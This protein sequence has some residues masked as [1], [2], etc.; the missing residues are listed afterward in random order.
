L[1]RCQKKGGL[2]RVKIPSLAGCIF[3]ILAATCQAGPG[4]GFVGRGFHGSSAGRGA[5]F[6]HAGRFNDGDFHGRSFASRRFFGH[7]PAVFFQPFVW[8]GYWYPYCDPLAYSYLQPDS[9]YQYWDNSDNSV[10]P[11]SFGGTGDRNPVVIVI[12]NTGNSRPAKSRPDPGYVDSGGYLSTSVAGQQKAVVQD[13][14]E[15][16]ES[17]TDAMAPITPPIPQA[18]PVAAPNTHTSLQT[19]GNVFNKL[20][21]VSWLEDGGKDVVFVKNLETNDVQRITSQPNIDH[22]RLVELHPNADPRQFE[23]IITNGSQQGAVRF[24]VTP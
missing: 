4:S 15:K 12:N 8:P 17:R 7:G 2:I 5:F 13:P 14:A 1:W 19:Q 10:Q 20:V 21:L 16:A 9:D 3:L 11:Q 18:T 23:A 6:S 22:F 24:A